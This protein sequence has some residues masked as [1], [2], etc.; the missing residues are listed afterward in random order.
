MNLAFIIFERLGER[1]GGRRRKQDNTKKK[2]GII[3]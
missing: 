2:V 1:A 3:L